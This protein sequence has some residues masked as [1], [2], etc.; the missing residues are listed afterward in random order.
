MESRSHREMTQQPR[1]FIETHGCKLNQADTQEMV[2]RFVRAG[3][4]VAQEPQ[5]VDV[6]VVNTCIV[7]HTADR[8]ARQALR[9]ARRRY[10]EALVVATGCYAQR[11]PEHLGQVAGV[12]LVVGNTEKEWLVDRVAE[13]LGLRE[14]SCFTGSPMPLEE[15][16]PLRTRAMVKIQEG[17]D[18]VCAYCIVPKVRGRERSVPSD[19]LVEQ[20]RRLVEEGH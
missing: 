5:G 2:G 1:V 20:V 4:Q 19:Y 14:V 18:Q 9:S 7:T 11:A 3:Y 15:T 16:R 13:T 6:Y 8:K 10:P 12:G 17:C